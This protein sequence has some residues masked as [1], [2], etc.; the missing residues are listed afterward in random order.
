MESARKK[1]FEWPDPLG[2]LAGFGRSA[3]AVLLL[4]AMAAAAL[5][6]SAAPGIPTLDELAADWMQEDDIQNLPSVNNFCGGLKAGQ[7]LLAIR[8]LTCPP[9]TQGA[10]STATFSLGNEPVHATESR[11]F[12]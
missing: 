6:T 10:E 4:M 3:G 8:V 11:W 1:L 5:S 2:K 12:P 7:N 9:Y